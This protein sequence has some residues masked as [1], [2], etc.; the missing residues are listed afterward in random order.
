MILSIQ[1]TSKTKGE[2]SQ[3][4]QEWQ[5]DKSFQKLSPAI[6]LKVREVF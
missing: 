5:N 2:E 4:S 6:N 1:N 3:I